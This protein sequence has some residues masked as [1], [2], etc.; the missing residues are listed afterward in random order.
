MKIKKQSETCGVCKTTQNL[1][2]CQ[3]CHTISYCS[4]MHKK[5]HWKEHKKN[6]VEY[7]VE[8]L[9]VKTKYLRK[10]QQFDRALDS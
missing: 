2:K 1:N 3:Q 6:G 7:Q 5:A 10:E 8:D 9:Y 4:E